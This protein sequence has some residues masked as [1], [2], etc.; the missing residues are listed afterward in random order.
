MTECDIQRALC[1]M[2]S[3][4]S[5]QYI[6][7]NVY[8][9]RWESDL[10]TVTRAGRVD[11][12]EAKVSRSDFGADQYKRERHEALQVGARSVPGIGMVLSSRPNSF[13]YAVPDGLIAPAEVPAH[14]GLLYVGL[15]PD[16]RGWYRVR[17]VPAKVAPVLHRQSISRLQIQRLL[18]SC[19]YRYLRTWTK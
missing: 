15:E 7:P 13:W 11:E 6:V 19:Y 18:T 4:R 3:E 17:R 16:R 10:I 14:A 5:R 1:R 2:A 8:L 12:Y 9:Y